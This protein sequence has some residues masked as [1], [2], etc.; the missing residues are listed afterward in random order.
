MNEYNLNVDFSKGRISTNLKKLVQNDYN[1][2]KLNFTFDK[3]GRVLFKM[4]YPDGTQYVDEIQN[5]ELVFGAGILNQEGTYE[6][7]ISLY[8][9]DGR[10]TDYATKSF[11]VRSEL[12]DTDELVEPD[13]RVP[14]LDSLI[15]EVNAIKASAEA[16]EFDGE[17]GE[18]GATPNV[19]A[20][21]T[22]TLQAG[23][24]AV[25]TRTGTVDNPIF[26]FAI[27]RGADGSNGKDGLTTEE[28]EKIVNNSLENF[29]GGLSE[30]EVNT[31][32]EEAIS[33]AIGSAL[34]GSY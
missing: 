19:L 29:E 20:G 14:I 9:K 30:E 11:E 6:Y 1:T 10:L 16:G 33:K 13:D 24:K 25:V 2:T 31:L 5:N 15:N 32:I 28:V 3:K 12:I 22:V 26:N 27:P 21:E 18:P 4:L 8:T 23:A 34:E 7:E 17:K